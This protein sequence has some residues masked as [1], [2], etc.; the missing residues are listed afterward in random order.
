MLPQNGFTEVEIREALERVIRSQALS[1]SAQLQRLLRTVVDRTIGNQANLLKEYNLGLEVFQRP[2]DYD[3]KVDPI[4][5]VQARRLR[6]K[7]D[8]YYAGEGAADP[9]R[10][11][12]PR[13]AYI[14]VFSVF[15]VEQPARVAPEEARNEWR[16]PRRTWLGVAGAGA[17]AAFLLTLLIASRRDAEDTGQQRGVAVLAL[18]NFDSRQSLL[19]DQSTELLTTELAKNRRLRVLSRT[20]ASRFGDKAA[21]LPEIAR[22]MGVRWVVEGGLGTEGQR[23]YVKL[24]A[25]DSRTDRKIWADVYDCESGELIAV[26]VR[27][28][29]AIAKAIE[30]ELAQAPDYR[31]GLR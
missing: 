10:I 7:L 8:E 30:A 2:P 5:R 17:I 3:P 18:K 16:L 13:G 27:A 22:A 12:M 26:N 25:V 14:P 19:A 15:P 4:V 31:P 21:S 9:V 28:A 20:T 24:R 11:Q 29:A 1:G 23:V 6:A